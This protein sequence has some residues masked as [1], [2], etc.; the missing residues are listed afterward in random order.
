[1]QEEADSLSHNTTSHNNFLILAVVVPEKS[2]IKI[3]IGKKKE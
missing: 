1:M 3:L 2:W